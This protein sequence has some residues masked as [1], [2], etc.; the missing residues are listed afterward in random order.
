MGSHEVTSSQGEALFNLADGSYE[1]RIDHL[2]YQFWT[3]VFAVPGTLSME[4]TIPHQDVTITVEGDYNGDVEPRQN[5]KVYLFTPALII[6]SGFFINFF[7]TCD[8]AVVFFSISLD[9]SNDTA[10]NTKNM[11][12]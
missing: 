6:N 5:L 3:D 7:F 1:I 2:G 11:G 10:M 12:R 9:L 4:R 8:L